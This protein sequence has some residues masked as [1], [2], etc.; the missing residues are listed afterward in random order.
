MATSFCDD[1]VLSTMATVD[2]DNT[3]EGLTTRASVRWTVYDGRFT[4]WTRA[5]AGSQ[6]VCRM[7]YTV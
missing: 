3:T 2:A 4:M 6:V 5:E 7:Y 1:F